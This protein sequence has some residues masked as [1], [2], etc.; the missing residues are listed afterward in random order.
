MRRLN[1]GSILYNLSTK[2]NRA[3]KRPNCVKIVA[4]E[5][6][7]LTQY[8]HQIIANQTCQSH[9]FSF[10]PYAHFFTSKPVLNNLISI[11]LDNLTRKTRPFTQST[12][13][14]IQNLPK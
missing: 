12:N 14:S 13:S 9:Y 4:L 10:I 8:I 11:S 7:I 5:E 3:I 6:F 2:F 1:A